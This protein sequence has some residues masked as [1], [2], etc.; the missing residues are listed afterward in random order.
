MCEKFA[1]L[2]RGRIYVPKR[3]GYINMQI[4][5]KCVYLCVYTDN[6][7]GFDKKKKKGKKRL[8]QDHLQRVYISKLVHPNDNDISKLPCW[9]LNQEDL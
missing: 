2:K 9:A 7:S 8:N 4:M 1:N 5:L 3:R 6:K